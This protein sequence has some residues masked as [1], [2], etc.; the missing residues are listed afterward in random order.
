MSHA[1]VLA[2]DRKLPEFERLVWK[3]MRSGWVTVEGMFGPIVR[4]GGFHL[5]ACYCETAK[6]V[7]H[8]LD[9]QADQQSLDVLRAYLSA[10]LST[11]ETVELWGIWEGEYRND[12]GGLS[13]VEDYA[14]ANQSPARRTRHTGGA[15]SFG[16]DASGST[17]RRAKC[18]H[19]R[20]EEEK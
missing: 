4:P 7:Y 3:Q 9:L 18:L 1:M 6:T 20:A 16:P 2:A 13:F 11:G 15:V 14:R 10:T 8:D 17:P 5:P 12:Q 19:H